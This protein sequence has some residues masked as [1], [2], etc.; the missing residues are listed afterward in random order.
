MFAGL[1]RGNRCA[2]FLC[3]W[4]SFAHLGNTQ[5]QWTLRCFVFFFL[6]I[7]DVSDWGYYGVMAMPIVLH[8][9][10]IPHTTAAAGSTGFRDKVYGHT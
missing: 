4:L 6:G 7:E 2:L 8:Q 1:G 3:F 5:S 10:F 9:N